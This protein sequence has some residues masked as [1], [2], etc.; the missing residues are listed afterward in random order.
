MSGRLRSD[1]MCRAVGQVI[2]NGDRVVV[3]RCH[4]ADR[5]LARL[6]GLLGTPR[7][8]DGEGVWIT[9]CRS[10]HMVGMRYPVS[11]AFIDEAGRVRRIVDRLEPGWH[12]ASARAHAVI[13]ASVGAFWQVREGDRLTLV[14]RAT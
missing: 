6:V 10:V 13:E 7:L 9:P 1:R 3:S 12:G 11:C 2:V 8:E 14:E 4:V 5:P